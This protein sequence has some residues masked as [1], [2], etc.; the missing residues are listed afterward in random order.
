[1]PEAQAVRSKIMAS[2]RAKNTRP[3]LLVRS[4]LHRNGFR[5]RIHS[6]KLPGKPDIVLT[7]H[8]A[9]ILVNGCF[10]HGH[11]CHIFKEPR[12][13]NWRDKIQKNRERDQ[14]NYSQYLELG[15]RVLVVWECALQGK[16]RL[17]VRE[18]EACL[19]NWLLYDDMSAEIRGSSSQQTL[20][21]MKRKN[22]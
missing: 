21:S 6:N 17:P 19:V 12:Q 9:I 18:L 13:K 22:L 20:R 1:M 11:D 16:T 14:E 4:L 7:K 3:E 5:F 8:R 2:I 10:W 15:W